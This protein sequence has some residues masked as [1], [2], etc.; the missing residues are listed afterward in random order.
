MFMARFS[1]VKHVSFIGLECI[2]K[3]TTRQHQ[4]W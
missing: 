1:K 4:Y 2:C 3:N